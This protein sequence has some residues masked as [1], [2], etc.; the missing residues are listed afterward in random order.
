MTP[1]QTSRQTPQQAAHRT[2]HTGFPLPVPIELPTPDRAQLRRRAISTVR[3][4]LRNFAPL[5]RARIMRRALPEFAAARPLRKSFEELG[6]TYLKFGQL[7][8]SSPGVFGDEVA[9][10]FRSCLDTGPP[11]AFW[12]VR[13]TIERD[14][15]VPLEDVYAEFEREP[16]AAAS[17]AVVHRAVL[18]DGREVAVKI[19]RPGIESFVAADLDLMQPLFE[20]LARQIG[21]GIAGPLLQL[22]DG[23]REQVAEEMDLRNESQAMT[24]YRGLLE[25][26]DLPFIVIPEPYPEFSGRHVLTME[27]LDGVPIDDLAGIADFG[28]D[29]RPLVEEVVKAWFVTTIR[30]GTFHGDVHAGNLML[31]RDGRLGVIDWGIVGRLSH[32]THQFMRWVI[33]AALGDESAWGRI[34]NHLGHVYGAGV[35][36]GLGYS[37]DD[38]VDLIRSQMEPILTRPFGD[39]SLASMFT[40]P[41]DQMAEARAEMTEKKSAI[42]IIRSW[43]D[44]RRLRS[45]AE[46]HG[47]AGGDFDRGTFLIGK[48]LLYFERYGKMFLSDV[49]LLEDEKFFRALLEEDPIS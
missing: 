37:E 36:E 22:L 29:P 17:I 16:L 49:A 6:A 9:D 42:A 3:A 15:G 47:G 26:V 7:L 34:S 11:V 10:E 27:F 38:M 4:V 41:Q 12:R 25:K 30:N 5:I 45:L 39:V 21:V 14:L 43:R 19:L 40:M 23:F 46:D 1:N 35:M 8:G 48:Q 20:L 33:E 31:L 28:V 44:M 32:E 13:K 2:S 18:H 24:H